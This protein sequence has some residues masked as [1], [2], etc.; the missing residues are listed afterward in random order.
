M[1]CEWKLGDKVSK[2]VESSME[3]E[4]ERYKKD[5]TLSSYVVMFSKVE[6]VKMCSRKIFN[7]AKGNLFIVENKGKSIKL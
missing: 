1:N 5:K 4:N 3:N 7:H 2:Y 6:R